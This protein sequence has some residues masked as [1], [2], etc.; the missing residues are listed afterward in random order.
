MKT[1]ELK[2]IITI[3]S[4][5]NDLSKIKYS[6]SNLN[7]IGFTNNEIVIALKKGYDHKIE[8]YV[9]NNN[10]IF[11]TYQNIKE[12]YYN[13]SSNQDFDYINFINEGDTYSENAKETVLTIINKNNN[14]LLF[15]CPIIYNNETYSLN[16]NLRNSILNIEENNSAIWIHLNS[17][18]ISKKLLENLKAPKKDLAYYEEDYLLTRLIVLSGGYHS[19]KRITLLSANPLETSLDRSSAEYDIKWYQ[20]VF[21]YITELKNFSNK[22]YSCLINYIAST[23]MY[24]L[25]NIINSNV[26]AKNKHILNSQEL[27][28]F[29]ENISISLKDIDDENIMNTS[30]NKIVNY[31]LLKLKHNE[32]KNNYRSY[33]QGIYIVHNN[34]ILFNASST[35]IKIFLMEMNKH[36]LHITASYPFPFD[37]DKLKIY[38]KYNNKKIYVTKNYLYSEYRAFGK[39][40]YENYVFDINIPLSKKGTKEYIEFFLE[41]ENNS[42][43]LALNFNK[44][45]ARLN[46]YKNSYWSSNGFNINYRKQSIMIM[47]DNKLRRIKREL[48]YLISLIRKNK[49]AKSAAILRIIYHLTKPFFKKEIWLF[50]DKIY[51]GGDNGEYLYTYACQQK[52]SIKKYYILNKDCLD[53]K[54]FKKENKKYVVYGT[55]KHKLLF[56]NSNIVFA[57]HNSSTKH[58]SFNDDNELYFRDLYNNINVC[59]QHG[60]SVQYIPN[61]VNRINDNLK[62]FFLA[63]E[64]E[65]ENLTNKEY[66]YEGYE[67]IL[68]VTGSPRY[69]GLKNNDQRQILITPTWRNYLA[70][71]VVNI[72]S[73]RV[74]NKN[75]KNSDYFKIYNSLINNK[76]LIKAAEKYNYK[77]IYL[78]HPCTSPQMEDFDQ[79]ENVELLAATE[80][81]NY[82]KILTESSL[83]VTDYSGV[84]FDFAYMYKPIIYFH[85]TELPPS[86][87]EGAYKYETMSLGEIV[88]SNEE[89]VITLCEYMK[90]NCEI[91]SEY[92]KRIDKFFKYHDNNNCQRIYDITSK[93]KKDEKK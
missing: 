39:K 24:V 70:T 27:N 82:E 60:L 78:L 36:I 14:H 65:K 66:A 38:I 49:T 18:F 11:F 42:L 92:K 51:K 3:V 33:Q 58:H 13:I 31:H 28:K 76:N 63:S 91:K 12:V 5:E 90:N 57:T 83:M 43:Q 81:L 22:E 62:G 26:N 93:I 7:K 47:Q 15:I 64:V 71:P 41:H 79:N 32:T 86:Y 89:L 40:L 16:K 8:E 74:Y 54:R 25:K 67:D 2:I 21:D 30:G 6:I 4:K 75:F 48:K 53:A 34:K 59:I 35:K 23:I 17:V 69:D 9:K 1:E 37:E 10:F 61:L 52:D 72:S 46:N 29:Y 84:Q 19:I 77:I 80:D 45:L 56:L 55:L 20:K 50:E 68:H 44:P 85:P 87:D 73:G 88:R